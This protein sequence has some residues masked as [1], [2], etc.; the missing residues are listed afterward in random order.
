MPHFLTSELYPEI[1]S[2]HDTWYNGDEPNFRLR[3]I[4]EAATDG[5]CYLKLLFYFN[6]V[7]ELG[8]PELRSYLNH[9][10]SLFGKEPEAMPVLTELALACYNRSHGLPLAET[11]SIT[12]SQMRCVIE[13]HSAMNQCTARVQMDEFNGIIH[14]TGNPTYTCNCPQELC[15]HGWKLRSLLVCIAREG[16]KI[17]A[18]GFDIEALY[19]GGLDMEDEFEE[20][21]STLSVDNSQDNQVKG[22]ITGTRTQKQADSPPRERVESVSPDRTS[23]DHPDMIKARQKDLKN[24][25]ENRRTFPF[26]KQALSGKMD[27]Q[28]A[29]EI[30]RDQINRE[31]RKREIEC[32]KLQ[33]EIR[34]LRQQ[35]MGKDLGG[36]TLAEEDHDTRSEVTIK[37]L[38]VRS[39][40]ASTVNPDDSAS[41]IIYN[42][43]SSRRVLMETG[44]VV[45]Q[46]PVL[47]S[48]DSQSGRTRLA[49][50][51]SLVTGYHQTDE[52]RETENRHVNRLRPI[53]GLPRPFTHQRLNFLANIHTGLERSLSHDPE[54]IIRCLLRTMKSPAVL[55][56]DDL[57]SQVLTISIDR[58]DMVYASNPFSLPYI[59]IGMQVTEDSVYKLFDLL[60]GEYRQTWFQEMKGLSVPD[61][62]ADYRRRSHDPVVRP[63]RKRSDHGPK[64]VLEPPRRR[65]GGRSILGF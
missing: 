25:N 2:T 3:T 23:E 4:A 58:H 6:V 5:F 34:F 45:V 8:E 51:N 55:P 30:L 57:L 13:L 16:V 65:N 37:P 15:T 26:N 27:K 48:L 9:L 43:G 38:S 10:K 39:K 41:H 53:N 11:N 21:Y 20:V 31:R 28:A 56:V 22:W 44:S 24:A 12:E 54:D 7:S 19:A 50:A 64:P 46:Q 49:I 62:H 47:S 42:P 60:K 17:G 35:N 32:E 63:A 1:V 29:E 61:F 14:L 18:S 59:E 36:H 33:D 40:T 52:L